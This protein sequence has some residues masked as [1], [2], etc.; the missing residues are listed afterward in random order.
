VRLP[1]P[2]RA[3]PFLWNDDWRGIYGMLLSQPSDI[4]NKAPL[5]LFKG[6]LGKR[7]SLVAICA[8]SDLYAVL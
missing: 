1:S 4:R 6:Q 3:G 2:P 5:S 8:R 7:G